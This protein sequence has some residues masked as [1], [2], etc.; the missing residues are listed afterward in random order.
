MLTEGLNAGHN[1]AEGEIKS[2]R[3]RI[4]HFTT[5]KYKKK[6]QKQEFVIS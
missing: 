4:F 3:M 6:I 1:N 2:I 5:N